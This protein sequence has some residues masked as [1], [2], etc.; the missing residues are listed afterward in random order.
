MRST[1]FIP[2]ETAVERY[3][4]SKEKILNKVLQQTIRMENCDGYVGISVDDLDAEYV[5]A[6]AKHNGATAKAAV[7]RPENH[8]AR[9]T[10]KDLRFL[11]ENWTTR[12]ID[13]LAA[14]IGKTP[15]ATSQIM[16]RLKREG[17]LI[18]RGYCS[19]K[20][21]ARKAKVSTST[22]DRL[23]AAGEVEVLR[24]PTSDNTRIYIKYA[25]LES[26]LE[27]RAPR[28]PALLTAEVT[29]SSEDFGRAVGIHGRTVRQLCADGK[30]LARW[31]QETKAAGAR[32][33]RWVIPD[34][35]RVAYLAE[36]RRVVV[37]PSDLPVPVAAPVEKVPVFVRNRSAAESKDR[38]AF[39]AKLKA[40]VAEVAEPEPT[41]A[42]TVETAPAARGGL[43]ARVASACAIFKRGRA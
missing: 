40:E 38:A 20:D 12:T 31:E 5:N 14:G 25:S 33:G 41:P 34:S 19:K 18:P 42:V 36:K 17:K 35:S 1:E 7:K 39:R 21:A 43:L 32:R 15:G 6:K 11:K 4:I 23:T 8:G 16:S 30:I 28:A 24:S 22:I 37:P 29:W 10:V 13:E 26:A 9:A 27:R 2:V 3:G